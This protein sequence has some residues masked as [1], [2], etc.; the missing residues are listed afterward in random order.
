[1]LANDIKTETFT[2]SNNIDLVRRFYKSVFMDRN[3]DICDDVMIDNYINHSELV[4]N[5]KNEF[6][7]YFSQYYTTFSKSG[8]EIV[9]IFSEN[10]LVCVYATHWASNK[11]F[12]VNFKAIDVYRI[13]SGKLV[14]HW[15]SIEALNRFSRFMFAVKSLLKL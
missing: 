10:D 6:K 15:D 12:S 11:L 7:K 4:R 3:V 9:K 5:G 13:D 1:M 2:R 14:E 8:S